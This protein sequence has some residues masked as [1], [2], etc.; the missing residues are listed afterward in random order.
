MLSNHHLQRLVGPA[1]R[2]LLS[3]ALVAR[4]HDRALDTSDPRFLQLV[5]EAIGGALEDEHVPQLNASS[6]PAHVVVIAGKL[7]LVATPSENP[8]VI[9]KVATSTVA[10]FSPPA[11]ALVN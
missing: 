10:S 6:D 1:S 5:N 3:A 9:A 2:A 7:A 8:R 4:A 11:Q